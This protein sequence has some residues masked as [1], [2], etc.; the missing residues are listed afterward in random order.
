VATKLFTPAE[1]NRTLPLVKRIVADILERGRVFR[2]L[3]DHPQRS[4]EA[5]DR[6]RE[7]AE[8]LESLNGE[9]EDIGCSFRDY[10]FEVGLVDFPALIDGEQ[11]LLCWRSD[12]PELRF[13][14]RPEAGYAGRQPIPRALLEKSQPDERSEARW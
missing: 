1:A 3:A 10:R 6:L 12:E 14:H 13:F 11:V 5:E 7:L 9:L 8:E 4:V 2:E